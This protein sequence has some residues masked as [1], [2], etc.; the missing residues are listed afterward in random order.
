MSVSV[1]EQGLVTIEDVI[2]VKAF[3]RLIIVLL[4]IRGSQIFQE[5]SILCGHFCTYQYFLICICAGLSQA[6]NGLCNIFIF[7]DS[8]RV[9]AYISQDYF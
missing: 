3:P 7:S 6:F 8:V 2:L 4:W 5:H 1:G 9:F